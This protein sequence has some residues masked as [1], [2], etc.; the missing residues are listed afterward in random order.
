MNI[1]NPDN[2]D[3]VVNPDETGEAP[4]TV[5]S[6]SVTADKAT[7]KEGEFVTFTIVTTML[8]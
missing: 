2:W 5:P 8:L 1:E 6:Y 7:V 4:S 3:D